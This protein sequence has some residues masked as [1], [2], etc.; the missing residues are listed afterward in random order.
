M[1]THSS[2]LAWRTPWTEG[3]GG[4][5]SKGWQRVRH[6]WSNLACTHACVTRLLTLH[7]IRAKNPLLSEKWCLARKVERTA[8]TPWPVL[9]PSG[10]CVP[11]CMTCSQVLGCQ[12]GNDQRVDWSLQWAGSLRIHDSPPVACPCRPRTY[13]L[14]SSPSA[15]LILPALLGNKS[16]FESSHFDL[17]ASEL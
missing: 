2:I 11:S 12:Q 8:Q 16:W 9:A 14:S 5:L 4:L 3:P 1:A 17:V 7:D 10:A 15:L 13:P 6:D